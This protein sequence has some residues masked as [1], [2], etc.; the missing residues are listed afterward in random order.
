MW[1]SGAEEVDSRQSRQGRD[2]R[3][4]VERKTW[5]ETPRPVR[6]LRPVR[7]AKPSQPPLRRRLKGRGWGSPVRGQRSVK[8]L[9][10]SVNRRATRGRREWSLANTRKDSMQVRFG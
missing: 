6:K 10:G 9:T 1:G 8:T 3:L 2:L 5:G 4:K 7:E